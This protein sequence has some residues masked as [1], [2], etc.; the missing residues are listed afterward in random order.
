MELQEKLGECRGDVVVSITKLN[1]Q[2]IIINCGLI[3]LIE[4]IPDTTITMTTGRKI[5]VKETV[6]TVLERIMAYKEY[7]KMQL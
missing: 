7:N 1:G 3:E 4:S 2:E 6:D 5:I